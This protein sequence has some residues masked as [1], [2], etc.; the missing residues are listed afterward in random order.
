MLPLPHPMLRGAMIG[1]GAGM[2]I[3]P[4][5]KVSN[6]EHM[7]IEDFTRDVMRGGVGGIV[8]GM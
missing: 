7:I 5:N 3:N 4:M 1:A 6:G 2:V 8:V